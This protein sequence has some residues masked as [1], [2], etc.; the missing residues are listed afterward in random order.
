MLSY[1]RDTSIF[2]F[3]TFSKIWNNL[4]LILLLDDTFMIPIILADFSPK[5]MEL[6]FLSGGNYWTG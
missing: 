2:F 4:H 6:L 5:K 3:L 1:R